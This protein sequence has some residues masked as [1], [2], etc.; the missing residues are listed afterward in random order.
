MD[1]RLLRL[2]LEESRGPLYHLVHVQT[3]QE[4]LD[5]L[6]REAFGLILS[7]L[8]LPDSHDLETF[9]RLNAKAPGVPIVVLSGSD[10][11]IMAVQ[12]VR[13]G[14]QDYL[15]K[16]RV[17]ANGLL[18]SISYAIERHR[19]DVALQESEKH[20]KHL[21]ESITDYVYT[22]KLEAGRPVQSIHA[23]GCV[24]VTGYDP[25]DFEN[26]NESWYKMV[27]EADRP[28]VLS[29]ASKIL[30]GQVPPVLEHRILHK[31]GHVRWVRHALVPNRDEHGGLISYD[32]CISD[33]T[34]RKEA[35][36]KLVSSEA[37]YHSLVENLPQ[38]IFRKDLQERFTFANQRFC[39]MLG[40]PLEEIMGKTDFD[41]YPPEMAS[42][43]Q[44]DDRWVIETGRIFET[45]E[46]NVSPSGE[47]I[48]VQVV[49]TPI[50]DAKGQILGTQCIFWDITERKRFEEELKNAYE[51]LA[52]NE[53]A[54]RKSNEALRAA[55]MQLIQA[56][57]MESVGT[58]AAGVAHEV[59]NP[60]AILMMGLSYLDKKL[61]DSDENILI[62]LKEMR[63]AISRADSIT[64]GLLDFSSNRQL[65]IKPE[66][67]NQ[68]ILQTLR[69]LRHAFTQAKIELKE[70]WGEH[71]PSVGIDKRQ[72]QQVFVN[73]FMNAIQAMP[74]GGAVTI[75]TYRKEITESIRAEGSR[76]GDRLWIGDTVVVAEVEDS[77]PGIP[78]G[79][80]VKI[81]DP[82]FTTKPTGV[83]TGL[84]LP[85]S[86]KII[87]L[88]GGVMDLKNNPG[89][90]VLATIMLKPHRK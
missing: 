7:D 72:V 40:K 29:Q 23:P 31:N 9:Q 41:F 13:E 90:G 43:Y 81:F 56:E 15:V 73:L 39:A 48:Y 74:E 42:K 3:L 4:G 64:L 45:V 21:L 55:Q 84:G 82:F 38:N 24:A 85:V 59:K 69:M 34:E 27:H 87:E 25:K 1:A 36:E 61:K 66:N 68:V 50:Y 52:R 11:E 44:K 14:A 53:A 28:A 32:G 37:F 2:F 54:L 47:T 46:E 16:G 26:S 62:V 35:E 78:P 80:L 75:R 18:R 58:L 67:M 8:S 20:Y 5:Q 51:E 30:A 71:L 88:H 79:H 89:R 22:V 70:E 19:A 76:Q 57:K 33:I 6:S 10:D 17:D 77:G 86:K 60:L 12:A 65:T 83:G 63:E 49:K